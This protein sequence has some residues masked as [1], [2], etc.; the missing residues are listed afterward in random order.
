MAAAGMRSGV[1]AALAGALLFG[2]S[3]PI[4]KLLVG[5]L[6][7]L[8]LAGLLYAGSGA[9]LGLWLLVRRARAGPGRGVAFARGDY[10]WLAGAVIAGG[11]AAPVLL[12]YGLAA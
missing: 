11:I 2:A 4:A 9:G 8:L 5:E 12:M 7:P 6:D 1:G 3:P 10:P